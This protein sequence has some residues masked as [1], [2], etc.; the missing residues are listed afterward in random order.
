MFIK[1]LCAIEVRIKFE[2]DPYRKN[3]PTATA[4]YSTTNSGF[5]D[6]QIEIATK[7]PF[8]NSR[9]MTPKNDT[10][11]VKT[12]NLVI[13]RVINFYLDSIWI[14]GFLNYHSVKD[15]TQ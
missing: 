9:S 7:T 12:A 8:F 1:L 6:T 2:N 10:H 4:I 14:Y 5:V 15:N 3:P 11:D 13:E